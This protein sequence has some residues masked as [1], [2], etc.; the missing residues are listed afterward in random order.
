[1]REKAAR[2]RYN[3]L[4]DLQLMSA[5]MDEGGGFR[6]P[7]SGSGPKSPHRLTTAE[8]LMSLGTGGEARA[9]AKALAR[10]REIYAKQAYHYGTH[11]STS[12][13][14]LYYMVR[15]AAKRKISVSIIAAAS[16]S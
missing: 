12:A 13:V 11:Y 5:E 2:E 10:A 1:M 6:G 8:R 14:V 15:T 16:V 7:G 9:K 4:I 3:T